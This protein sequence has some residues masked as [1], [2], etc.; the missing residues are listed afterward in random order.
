VNGDGK[1][2]YEE[3]L[4]FLTTR[5]AVQEEIFSES[6]S[7]R[8]SSSSSSRQSSQ[9]I[10]RGNSKYQ[11]NNYVDDDNS[12]YEYG[13]QQDQR[14]NNNRPSQFPEKQMNR[15]SVHDDRDEVVER[16][17]RQLQ[18]QNGRSNMQRQQKYDQEYD[19]S[20]SEGYAAS[21]TQS[22]LN[23]ADPKE[24]EY[25]AKVY[26]QNLKSHLFKKASISVIISV[27]NHLTV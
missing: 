21:E 3:F 13:Q 10:Y 26:L 7:Q 22:R 6:A 4:H 15:L 8:P 23:S 27:H 5:S 18:Q 19:D 1:I 16:A 11:H 25:R 12:E 2:S 17:N 9:D 24:L 14:S 20:M